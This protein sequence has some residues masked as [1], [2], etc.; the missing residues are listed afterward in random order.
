MVLRILVVDDRPDVRLS[1]GFMLQ[2]IGYQV[3]EASG[4]REALRHL[5]KDRVDVVLTDLSMPDMDGL[6]LIEMIRRGPT[7][8]P[9]LIAVTGSFDGDPEMPQTAAIVGADAVLAKPISRDE[10]SRTLRRLM[11]E[12]RARP[13]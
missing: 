6:A 13:R 4:G 3:L 10:L 12:R 9:K 5:A 11:G 8:H 2:A 7:P 1:F